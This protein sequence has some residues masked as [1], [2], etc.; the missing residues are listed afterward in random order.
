MTKT[1]KEAADYIYDSIK[2][3]DS[4]E[5]FDDVDQMVIWDLIKETLFTKFEDK[6]DEEDLDILEQKIDDDAFIEEYLQKRFSNYDAVLEETIKDV[7][8]E[9]MTE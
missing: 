9:Y 1:I 4:E 7:L 3:I 6:L 5:T 2:N 8:M